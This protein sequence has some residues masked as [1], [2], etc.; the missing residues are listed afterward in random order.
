MVTV[1]FCLIFDQNLTL[2][3]TGEKKSSRCP[4]LQGQ[5]WWQTTQ[6]PPSNSSLRHHWPRTPVCKVNHSI[7]HTRR[8]MSWRLRR[9]KTGTFFCLR[10]ELL[11]W[12]ERKKLI[13]SSWRCSLEEVIGFLSGCEWVTQFML[14]DAQNFIWLQH[15]SNYS[16]FVQK[17]DHARE[18][19]AGF[20]TFLSES[21]LIRV[22]YLP[23]EDTKVEN[24]WMLIQT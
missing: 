12:N 13:C 20:S 15:V 22:F 5:T 3:E 14:P 6:S 23:Q 18:N 11:R 2:L 24:S 16:V 10:T 21:G 17:W 19:I 7:L 4:P 8:W 9:L 1:W